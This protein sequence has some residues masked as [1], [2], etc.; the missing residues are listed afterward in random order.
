LQELLERLE[1]NHDN[2]AEA[3]TKKD[4]VDTD[5]AATVSPDPPNVLQAMIQLRQAKSRANQREHALMMMLVMLMKSSQKL[6]IGT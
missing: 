6:I 2:C 4:A 3:L 1:E 5:S